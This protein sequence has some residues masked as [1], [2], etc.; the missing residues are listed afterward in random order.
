VD[1]SPDLAAGQS[2]QASVTLEGTGDVYLD[3]YNGQSDLVSAT[4]QLTSKPVTLTLQGDVPQAGSTHF[5]VR[6]GD[7][8]P[9][10]LDASAAT[11]Q[12]LVPQSGN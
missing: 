3:F 6:T 8:G 2:Y 10:D 11:I 12:A 1:P 4:V 9:V 7:A 5:Q